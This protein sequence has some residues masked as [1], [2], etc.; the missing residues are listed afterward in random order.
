MLASEEWR[1]LKSVLRD[2]REACEKN[3]ISLIVMYI[4]AAAHVYAQYST[5][6]SGEN[7]RRI[8]E[9]QIQAKTNTEEAMNQM[10][11]ELDVD[12][13]SLTPILEEAASRGKL[14][15]YPLDP[16]WNVEGTELAASYVAQNLK[17]RYLSASSPANH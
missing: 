7:W 13:I 2:V 8:R 15:Y 1:Q 9:Q 14:L 17:S 11:K 5:I 3:E 16:H 12:L 10:A 6:Q 4:P